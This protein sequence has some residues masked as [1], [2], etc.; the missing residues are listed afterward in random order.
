MK[1]ERAL[2]RCLQNP[3]YL[4]VAGSK[5]YGTA[6]PKSDHDLR[7]FVV[8][9]FE[10]TTGLSRFDQQVIREPDTVIYSIKRTFELLIRGDPLIY[11]ILC[12]PEPNIIEQSDIGRVLRRNRELFACKKFARRISGYAQ[13]EWRKVTGTQLVPIKRTPNEDEVIENIRQIFRPQKGE[14]DEII[15]LLLLRY[16]RE[17]RPAR[18]KLGAKR[19]LQIERYGYC[20]SSASHTIRLLGQLKELMETGNLTFPRPD[21]KLLLA[22]KQGTVKLAQVTEIYNESLHEAKQAEGNSTL[23]GRAPIKKIRDIFHEII[24]AALIQDKRAT[25]YA[26]AYRKKWE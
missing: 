4:V 1:Q 23:P 13:S 14:M 7:G 11:E 10:Y 9:P 2:E 3:D 17:T 25:T 19:K 6:T 15:R 21:A 18:R 22:I 26:Q 5:L 24:A 16:P 20:T 8:P 12:A